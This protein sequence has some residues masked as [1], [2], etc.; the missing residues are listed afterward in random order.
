MLIKGWKD[1]TAEISDN[2]ALVASL[3]DSQFFAPFKEEA[4]QWEARLATLSEALR[5]LHHAGDERATRALHT[6]RLERRISKLS[7]KT[8]NQVNLLTGHVLD[9]GRQELR[10]KSN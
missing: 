7:Q 6:L 9:L 4:G 10:S 5:I 1:V 8:P 2:Q 3:K